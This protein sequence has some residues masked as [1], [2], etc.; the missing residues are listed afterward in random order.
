[1]W[2]QG[3]SSLAEN[4]M[5]IHPEDNRSRGVSRLAG[6]SGLAMSGGRNPLGA[7]SLQVISR[8]S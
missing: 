7:K 5:I 6:F 8:P 2:V 4:S 3:V 1:M